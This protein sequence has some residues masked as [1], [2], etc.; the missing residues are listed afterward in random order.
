M[1]ITKDSVPPNDFPGLLIVGGGKLFQ[2]VGPNGTANA[3]PKGYEQITGLNAVKGLNPPE[4][5]LFAV[6]QAETQDVR[7]RDDSGDDPT[8][9]VGMLLKSGTGYELY[10]DGDLSALKF[11]QVAA[12]AKLNVS[13]YA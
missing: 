8:A 7:W 13:Y 9:T 3:Q 4:G 5:A 1:D 6:I 2:L 11:I 12:S 10:Y